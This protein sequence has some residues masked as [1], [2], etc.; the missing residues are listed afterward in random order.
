MH[1]V[2]WSLEN[3]KEKHRNLAITSVSNSYDCQ[4][5]MSSFTNTY[6]KDNIGGNGKCYGSGDTVNSTISSQTCTTSLGSFSYT[7]LMYY[8]CP[9]DSWCGNN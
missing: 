5:C 1:Q 4:S 8:I 2:D 6:C 7:G 9:F 3:Q